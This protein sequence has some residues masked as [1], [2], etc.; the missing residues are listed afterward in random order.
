MRNKL[1]KAYISSLKRDDNT[2]WKPIKHKKTPTAP[3][4]PIRKNS[5]PPGPWAKS[6]KETAALFAEHL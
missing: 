4:P 6:D 1:F 2:I 5:T 3:Q